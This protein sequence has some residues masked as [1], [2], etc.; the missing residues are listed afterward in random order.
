MGQG[1]QKG[2]D[3]TCGREYLCFCVSFNLYRKEKAT[4]ITSGH[5]EAHTHTHAKGGHLIV[6]KYSTEGGLEGET[7]PRGRCV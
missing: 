4:D 3:R 6:M 1:V 2:W 7:Q 5:S